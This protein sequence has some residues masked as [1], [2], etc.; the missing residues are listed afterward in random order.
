MEGLSV[1]KAFRVVDFDD[2]EEVVDHRLECPNC[3]AKLHVTAMIRRGFSMSDDVKCP[4]CSEVVA[5]IRADFGH[6]I[7]SWKPGP[8]G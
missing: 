4:A 5:E 8:R 1:T 2:E 3:G 7:T 6:T